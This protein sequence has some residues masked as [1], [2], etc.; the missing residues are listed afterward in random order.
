MF[1]VI[2]FVEYVALIS[3]RFYN[4]YIPQLEKEKKLNLEFAKMIKEING[5]MELY[6]CY[7]LDYDYYDHKSSS[8]FSLFIVKILFRIT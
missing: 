6:S 8:T 1:K 5:M 2:E 3:H 4:E 7:Q